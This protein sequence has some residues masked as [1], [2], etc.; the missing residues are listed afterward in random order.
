MDQDF[1]GEAFKVSIPLGRALDPSFKVM[2]AWEMDGKALTK[3]HGFPLRLIVPGF[4]GVRNCKWVEK[5]EI[6]NEEANSCM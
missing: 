1:Q 2:L 6:S 4:I 3:D 5:L